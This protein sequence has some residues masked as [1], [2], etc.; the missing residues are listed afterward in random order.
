MHAAFRAYF[1][2]LHQEDSSA[3]AS[4]EPC[5]RL[6]VHFLGLAAAMATAADNSWQKIL[7][8]S[9][10]DAEI[11]RSVATLLKKVSPP[12]T[13]QKKKRMRCVDLS[14]AMQATHFFCNGTLTK[15]K[16]IFS[17]YIY[18]QIGAV[19]KSHMSQI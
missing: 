18:I 11:M 9:L 14:L 6:A 4:S 17:S 2:S 13:P 15:K 8:E 3:A 5:S 16:R 12:P 19:A 10:E 7:A 1:K